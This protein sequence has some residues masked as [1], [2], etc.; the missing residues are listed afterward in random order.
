MK[1]ALKN[2]ESFGKKLKNGFAFGA[3]S[4]LGQKAI[5]AVGN[6]FRSLTQ[7]MSES[8]RTWDTFRKN[9]QMNGKTPAQINKI[10]R[11]LQ[12]FVS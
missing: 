5:G 9:M 1:N 7:E 6:A 2:T 8:T 11:S 3:F 4:S 10:Q 12:K